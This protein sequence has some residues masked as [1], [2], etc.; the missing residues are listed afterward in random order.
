[1]YTISGREKG[2]SVRPLSDEGLDEAFGFAVGPWSIGPSSSVFDSE[3]AARFG[4][5]LRYV[6]G[7]I[8]RKDLFGFDPTG[9]KPSYGSLKECAR[10]GP[11][12]VFKDFHIRQP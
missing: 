4:E 8:V 1:L 11:F 2:E 5:D 12:L 9:S 6:A 10:C 7:A 3:A